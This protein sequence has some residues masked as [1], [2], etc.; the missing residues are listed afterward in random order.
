MTLCHLAAEGKYENYNNYY[1]KV[2][3]SVSRLSSK[4]VN[5]AIVCTF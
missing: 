5:P 2:I 3:Y 4:R 1:D